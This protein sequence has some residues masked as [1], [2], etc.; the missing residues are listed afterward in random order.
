M[1]SIT[2]LRFAEVE[3]KMKVRA[4]FPFNNGLWFKE[5]RKNPC[6]F[7]HHSG[8]NGSQR[9]TSAREDE[10]DTVIK[11]QHAKDYRAEHGCEFEIIFEK[12]RGF[13]GDDA[14]SLYAKLVANQG[15]TKWEYNF[16]DDSNY[17]KAISLYNSGTTKQVDIAEELGLSKGH[18][19]RL[20][21][22]A[23]IDGK[24]E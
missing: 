8:K 17:E 6:C 13:E 2:L 19:S 14:R 21:K 16:L 12:N 15:R 23:K 5:Q 24:I 11:L 18:V 22:Q 20:F 10:L 4:G 3:K 1:L 9:G 7:I